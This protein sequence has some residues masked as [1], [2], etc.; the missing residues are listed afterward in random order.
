M[1]CKWGYSYRTLLS[2]HLHLPGGGESLVQQFNHADF[3]DVKCAIEML[4]K[5]EKW[6]GEHNHF[7]VLVA[8]KMGTG[9]TTLVR[10]LCGNGSDET[11]QN[12]PA[13]PKQESLG[14]DTKRVTPYNYVYKRI[15]FTFVDTPG[16]KDV[17]NNARD[18]KYLMQ[19][20][21]PDVLIFTMK[22]NDIEFHDDDIDTIKDISNA[23]GWKVWKKAIFLLTFANF[24]VDPD[25]PEGKGKRG[26][27]VFYNRRRDN[28]ALKVTE[29]LENLSTESD[30]AN[31]MPVLPVGLVRQPY[32]PSDERKTVSWVDEFW[33]KILEILTKSMEASR[34][35]FG[36]GAGSEDDSE[37]EQD[38][39]NLEEEEEAYEHVHDEH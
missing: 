26:H 20:Q 36:V 31:D 34:F 4:E 1:G 16:L 2:K 37:G 17:L 15:N 18:H 11:T 12:V 38:G 9:K 10:G 22:M 13:K 21:E 5:I 30:V 27:Y 25:I 24:V 32:I 6:L 29:T 3:G 7:T 39:E 23:F 35:K 19:M 28:F 33:D 8:G 14:A